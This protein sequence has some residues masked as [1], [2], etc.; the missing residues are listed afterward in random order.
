MTDKDF[1][2]KY[3]GAPFDT[4]ELVEVAL[5]VEGELGE[6]ALN[7]LKAERKFKAAL[8]KIGFEWG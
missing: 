3:D 6:A 5:K 2:E 4:D 7:Y 1:L 8:E